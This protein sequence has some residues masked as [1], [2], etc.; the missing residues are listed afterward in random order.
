MK[1]L[2]S[3]FY[4]VRN[5]NPNM[6][7]L[8]TAIYPPK[9]YGKGDV[10]ARFDK[11]GVIIGLDIP[12]FKFPQELFETSLSIEEQCCKDCPYYE[13][14]QK[15]WFDTFYW[16][17]FMKVYY[18]HLYNQNFHDIIKKYETFVSSLNDQF[19]LNIDTIILIVHEPPQ[20]RCSER[21][22]L[23]KYFEKNDEKLEEYVCPW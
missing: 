17:P 4:Q 23:Q 3:Y 19:H 13:T 21:I 6:I 2:I 15:G 1:W 10:A 22:V 12:E 14:I 8:S 7:P 5:F 9:W 18:N 20:R 11:N 16:C